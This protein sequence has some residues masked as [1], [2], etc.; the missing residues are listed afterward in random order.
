MTAYPI[1]KY[2]LLGLLTLAVLLGG[3]GVW[4]VT[5]TIAGA[6]V[7]S[8][9]VM[10]E[11]NRQ[12][13][14]HPDGGVVGEILVSNGDMVDAGQILLRL[15]S[16]LQQ[17]RLAIVEGQLFEA[18]ARQGRLLAERDGSG[19]F[20][21][22]DELAALRDQ[23]AIQALIA[24]QISL[25]DARA[26]TLNDQRAQLRE[27]I[28]Q[29]D[30]QIAG[31]AAQKT[32]LQIQ[33]DLIQAE[34]RDQ[35]DLLS[36]GLTQAG[37]VSALQRE[38]ARMQGGIGEIDASIAEARGRIAEIELEIL[39]LASSFRE[40]AISSLRDLE[41]AEIELREN[42]IALLETLSRMDI[43]A[44]RAGIIHGLSVHAIR[45]VVQGAE[46]IL[47][48]IPQDS[49]LI[50]AAKIPTI[51]IDQVFVGQP[52]RL[53]FAA[54]DQRNTPELAGHIARLS[55]DSL[56]DERSGL[57]YYAAELA[58]DPGEM[59]LLGDNQTLLPGMPV[60]AFIATSER[61]PLSYLLKPMA[62][63]FN[64]AFREN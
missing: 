19:A 57:T 43:R 45:A 11:S 10:V 50:I 18:M 56:L 28:I 31:S 22:A 61:T 48:I 41:L 6:V 17:S 32:A 62:D 64:R 35:Q 47:Y 58:I 5:V 39:R 21:V 14:Q 30:N 25:F 33:L 36:R 9:Q 53:R 27:R 23:P 37:T 63:Y 29:I 42:R 46:P 49:P 54:F 3:L 15:D 60:E 38:S 2:G 51:D 34:L 16:T 7:A 12:V 8:G 24:G 44:P 1:R 52:A 4:S 13:V 20:V 40:E 26:A 55:P 59:A